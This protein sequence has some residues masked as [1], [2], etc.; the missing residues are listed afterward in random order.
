[1]SKSKKNARL[2]PKPKKRSVWCTQPDTWLTD[3]GIDTSIKASLTFNESVV[4]DV[5][6][7]REWQRHLDQTAFKT[8]TQKLVR[9]PTCNRRLKLKVMMDELDSKF[10]GF[11]LP[12]HKAK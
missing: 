1:M 8:Q 3:M 10:S 4:S 5:T 2:P 9:C 11:K 12:K 6:N 7:N